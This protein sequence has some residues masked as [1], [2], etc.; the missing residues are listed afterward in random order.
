MWPQCPY[1]GLRFYRESDALLFCERE[2]DTRQCERALFRFNAKLLILQG[3]SGAGKSSFLRAGLIPYLRANAEEPCV[4]L[5]THDGA[6]RCTADPLPEIAKAMIDALERD[7]LPV[8]ETTHDKNADVCTLV[9]TGTRSEV[10]GLL[11]AALTVPRQQLAAKLVDALRAT[12][13]ELSGKLVLVLDQAEE[14]L[15]HVLDDPSRREAVSAFF[16]FLEEVYLQNVDVRVIVSIRTEYYGRFRDELRISDDRMATR[17]RHGGV[18]PYM[19]RSIRDRDALYRAMNAPTEA[20]TIP[21]PIPDKAQKVYDFSFEADAL[22]KI[23]DN[24]LDSYR[25][26]SVTPALQIICAALYA[27]CSKHGRIITYKAFE[28]HGGSDGMMRAYVDESVHYAA[29]QTRSEPDQWRALLHSLVSRQGGGA[30]V[31]LSEPV[32]ELERRA[33]NK[34]IRRKVRETL[35]ALS[36]GNR[37]LLRGEPP[38]NPQSYSLQHD[39]LASVLVRWK[40]EIDTRRAERLSKRR[41]FY[42]LVSVLAIVLAAAA[43]F[44]LQTAGRGAEL[45]AA[46]QTLIDG[47]NRLAVYAP[48]ANFRQSLVLLLANLEATRHRDNFYERVWGWSKVSPE[49]T[50]LAL[51]NTLIRSPVMSGTAVSVGIDPHSGQVAVLSDDMQTFSIFALPKDSTYQHMDPVLTRKLPPPPTSKQNVLTSAAGF[52]DG[53]GPV[54]IVSGVAYYWNPDGTLV[55]RDLMK[56]MMP[57]VIRGAVFPHFEFLEGKLLVSAGN[58]SVSETFEVNTVYV[59]ADDLAGEKPLGVTRLISGLSRTFGPVFSLASSLPATYA[60]LYDGGER[61]SSDSDDL[62]S[63]KF[64]RLV[65]GAGALPRAGLDLSVSRASGESAMKTLS[66]SRFTALSNPSQRQ[67]VGL[68]F[69]SNQDSLV[70]KVGDPS[71]LYY[72][73]VPAMLEGRLT[74]YSIPSIDF[75]PP[76]NLFAVKPPDD[77]DLRPVSGGLTWM[78]P[79]LAAVRLGNALR[80]AWTAPRG[81]W[82]GETTPS[83]PKDMIALPEFTGPLMSGSPGGTRLLFSNDGNMLILLQQRDFRSPLT[84]RLWDLRNERVRLIE[85]AQT[86]RLKALACDLL[87][88][89]SMDEFFSDPE[90]LLY[91]VNAKT[92]QCPSR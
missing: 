74:S 19:L 90:A 83:H 3:V 91:K 15:T 2:T 56:K 14:V 51:R 78:G 64:E 53:L 76:T 27:E 54:A 89:A 41:I 67:P 69:V 80:V 48:K 60:Y 9:D 40:T 7:T 30:L 26:G 71:K 92:T 45:L 11:R 16:F 49:Q 46:K 32:E 12:C 73:D 5:S 10:C 57:E 28:S 82:I 6:I 4:F 87:A 66:I 65:Y 34:G 58:F 79:P 59:G 37:P 35:L 50:V 23:I 38:E 25:A 84:F 61:P 18:E 75:H 52:I 8:S 13:A 72:I 85:T 33:L 63:R 20:T 21:E 42:A 39:V 77:D 29:K 81:V 36:R 22:R 62:V 43:L 88:T 86:D 24:V 1:P 70:F 17:P 68:A 31:S 55:T 44:A 47:R